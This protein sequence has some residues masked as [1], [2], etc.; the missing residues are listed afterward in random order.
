MNPRLDDTHAHAPVAVR[1]AR[2]ADVEFVCTL[3]RQA[4]SAYGDY[5]GV[6]PAWLRDPTVRTM[7]AEDEGAL[8]G[9]AMLRPRRGRRLSGPRGGEL[10][11]LAVVPE[12]RQQGI[13]RVLLAEIERCARAARMRE[14]RLSTATTNVVARHLYASAGFAAVAYDRRS[15]PSGHVAL[16]MAKLL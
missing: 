8:V 4:F 14:L 11:A 12:R 13:G 15:Y 6:L 3:A 2:L 10:L 5:S 1:P 7:L 9:F 16:E